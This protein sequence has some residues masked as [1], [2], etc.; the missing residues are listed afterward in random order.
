MVLEEDKSREAKKRIFYAVCVFVLLAATVKVTIDTVNKFAEDSFKRLYAAYSKA[1]NLTVLQ[2]DGE[3]GCYFSSEKGHGNNFSGCDKFYKRFVSNLKVT[4]FC[5]MNAKQKGCIPNYKQFATK[6][7]C[8]GYSEKM[9]NIFD[10]SYVMHDNSIIVVFNM[11]AT[12]PK[13]I[14]AVDS[15][16]KMFPNKTGYDLFSLVIMKNKNGDY[17]FHPNVVYCLPPVKGGIQKL[18]DVYK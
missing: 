7:E 2:M 15:N 14:F 4:K 3:T 18:Q 13:P 17:Y 5:E 1:L 9:F 10:E 8:S 12:S 16:G 11:P 6:A